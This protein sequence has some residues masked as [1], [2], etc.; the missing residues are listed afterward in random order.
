LN[1]LIVNKRISEAIF[2]GINAGKSRHLG[3]EL[4]LYNQWL[5]KNSF[6][7]ALSSTFAYT[8][9]VNRFVDFTDNGIVYDHN[10]LPG[11]PKQTICLLLDWKIYKKLELN[12]DLRH[13]GKQLLNDANSLKYESYFISN[14]K[15]SYIMHP[16]KFGKLNLYAGVN[17]LGN[18]KYASMLI[19]NAQGFNN[20]EARY[21]YPGLPRH[22]YFGIQATF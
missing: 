12:A 14:L 13:T 18:T 7:G 15:V 20:S 16:A 10:F 17:N 1:N 11:I 19:V 22:G 9:S 3:F 8:R 4:L 2:T 21:Y 5:D 6:P